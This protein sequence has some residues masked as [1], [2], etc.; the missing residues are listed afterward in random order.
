MS[1]PNT[2]RLEDEA[3]RELDAMP[4]SAV[5]TT[6]EVFREIAEAMLAAAVAAE[7]KDYPGVPN[8]IEPVI[9]YLEAMVT[10]YYVAMRVSAQ[11]REQDT[12]L[13]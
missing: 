5:A 9:E 3:R 11:A 6:A 2:R 7:T 13:N 12:G 8:A 10:G 1:G 4:D